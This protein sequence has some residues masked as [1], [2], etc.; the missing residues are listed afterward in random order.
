MVRIIK[1]ITF[2]LLFF[3][4]FSAFAVTQEVKPIHWRDLHPTQK[5]VL[6]PVA[7]EWD[8]MPALLQKRMVGVA[9]RFQKMSPAEQKRAQANL[10][11]WAKLTPEQRAY[12]R[13]NYRQLK[14]L[15]PEK[16]QEIK[17][18]WRKEPPVGLNK[19]QSQTANAP[20]SSAH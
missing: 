12:A 17:K 7:Q 15:P 6:A 2:W 1:T 19:P 8:K 18:K 14:K 13:Q 5:Q 11:D 16:R 4:S 9:D 3:A 10:R 20:Q